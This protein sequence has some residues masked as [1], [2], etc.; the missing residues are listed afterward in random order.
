MIEG[1]CF[2]CKKEADPEV[3]VH[4]EC[5]LAFEMRRNNQAKVKL[6]QEAIRKVIEM[7]N[8]NKPNKAQYWQGRADF[9]RWFWKFDKEE[10][11]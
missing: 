10:L 11:I 1:Q 3:Y 7:E 2:L 8:L 6:H 4:Y 5:A 9:I